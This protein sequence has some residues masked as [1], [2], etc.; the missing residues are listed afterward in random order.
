MRRTRPLT[1]RIPRASYTAWRE[2]V[3]ISARTASATSSAVPCGPSDTAR[4]TAR[5][6]AVT[7]TSCWRSRPAGWLEVTMTTVHTVPNIGSRQDFVR[8]VAVDCAGSATNVKKRRRTQAPVAI[9]VDSCRGADQSPETKHDRSPPMVWSLSNM[10][11]RSGGE[12]GRWGGQ[13]CR[14]DYDLLGCI[15]AV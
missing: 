2:M 3:P 1:A 14:M 15:D 13:G 11:T 7:W 8:V 4:R 12:E 10:P 9:G 5:R 6:W